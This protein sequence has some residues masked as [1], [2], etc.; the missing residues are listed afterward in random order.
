MYHEHMT[1]VMWNTKGASTPV[2]EREHWTQ[3]YVSW[4]PRGS[5]LATVHQQGIALWG[6]DDWSKILRLEHPG[7][8][9]LDFSPCEKYL[10]T[11][12][13]E[14]KD[15]RDNPRTIIIWDVRTGAKLRG[16]T[17]GVGAEHLNWP[18]FKWS[19]DDKYVA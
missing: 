17:S 9:L 5:F 12:S 1:S 10:C 6:G 7:V 15:D 18:V 14:I 19:H 4:S 2:V 13:N 16:F 8:Q 11:W 3:H